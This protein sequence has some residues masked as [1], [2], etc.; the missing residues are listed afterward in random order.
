M[1]VVFTLSGIF[2]LL[3]CQLPFILLHFES[4]LLKQ[5]DATPH[6][7]YPTHIYQTSKRDIQLVL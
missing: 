7:R 1:R 3:K 6:L 2:F 5:V 4:F